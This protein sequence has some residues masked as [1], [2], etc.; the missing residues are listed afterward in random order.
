MPD[1]IA[2]NPYKLELDFI[3]KSV[4]SSKV[5]M[6]SATYCRW[7]KVAAGYFKQFDIN[8]NKIEIDKKIVHDNKVF[9]E[10]QG[11]NMFG[12]LAQATDQQATVPKV[13]ICGKY[14]GG[15]DAVQE[16]FENGNL[17][18]ILEQC[19]KDGRFPWNPKT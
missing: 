15:C 18:R 9:T 12:I 6:F 2:T 10:E 16:T 14:L 19:K 17:E 3:K 1:N 8:V 7:C 5:V 11:R 13:F 4:E